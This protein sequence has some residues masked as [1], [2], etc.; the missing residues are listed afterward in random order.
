[1]G[2]TVGRMST[3]E[4]EE[5]SISLQPETVGIGIG[6]NKRQVEL[7]RFDTGG[8]L[9][10][11][12]SA[13]GYGV[14]RGLVSLGVPEEV[15]KTIPEQEFKLW[16][17]T[18]IYNPLT[19]QY[20]PQKINFPERTEIKTP[21]RTY[22]DILATGRYFVPYVGA[23]LFFG[24][25]GEK[26]YKGTLTTGEALITGGILLTAGA[27]RGTR[28]LKNPRITR[29]ALIVD[30][31]IPTPF[32][33]VTKATERNIYFDTTLGKPVVKETGSQFKLLGQTGR[34]GSKV[35]IKTPRSIFFER[36]Y[37]QIGVPKKYQQ[38]G[39]GKPLYGGV[40]QLD[41]EGYKKALELLKKQGYTKSQARNILRLRRPQLIQ[42]Y[43]KGEVTTLATEDSL[44]IGLFGKRVTKG[45]AGEKGGVKFLVRK[46]KESFIDTLA[47]P[48]KTEKGIE[49]SEFEEQLTKLWRPEGKK[50]ELFKG[51][52]GTK[53]IK[54]YPGAELFGQVDVSRR[55]I[56]L[57]RSFETGKAKVL[58]SKGE[59]EII[60][61]D[62]SIGESLG[63]MGGG[64]KSS[65]QFLEQMYKL[66]QAKAGTVLSI[67]KPKR[68]PK[69]SKTEEVLDI[70][71]TTSIWAGTGLYERT[72]GVSALEFGRQDQTILPVTLSGI[73]Q[74]VRTETRQ[75]FKVIQDIRPK[76]ETRLDV[77]PSLKL[78]EGLKTTLQER[79]ALKERQAQKELLKQELVSKQAVRQV[80]KQALATKAVTTKVPTIKTPKIKFPL[81]K[82]IGD[83]EEEIKIGEDEFEVFIKKKGKDISIGEFK[84]LPSA[85]T[86]LKSELLETLRASG[87]VTKGG[88]KIELDIGKFGA[89][90]RPSKRDPFRIVQRKRRRIKTGGEIGE[91]LKSRRKGGFFK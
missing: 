43:V 10:L 52:T 32:G 79:I 90:F 80:M 73:I 37:K 21:A 84:T 19:G 91:I 20:D 34:E 39:W 81:F 46:P 63:F 83:D 50:I 40:Y 56:P 11:Y 86:T 59:P 77:K 33:T 49:I 47:K 36:V 29:E 65:K 35:V 41:K 64:K 2:G 74:P 17:G 7:S 12:G 66:E 18:G 9:G 67:V 75:E 25:V 53:S 71:P 85:E 88:K 28:F 60:I 5:Y 55:V 48:T 3:Q 51:I 87:F 24:E 13:L 72:S 61:T 58:V 27:L 82:K 26:A 68:V 42:D 44:K 22:G 45:I 78:F 69:V 8:V 38:T 70:T 23:P 54:E 30:S 31:K 4:G 6:L 76:T 89:G 62:L 14:E 57:K 16:A 15:E 1:M